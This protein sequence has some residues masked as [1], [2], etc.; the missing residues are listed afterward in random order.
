LKNLDRQFKKGTINTL[1]APNG[2]GKTTIIDLLF[3]LYQPTEGVVV[4]NNKYK[5]S[6]L[7]LI[8]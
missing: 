3:G 5:L 1:Q 2:F 4:I 6:E 8:K 7:N